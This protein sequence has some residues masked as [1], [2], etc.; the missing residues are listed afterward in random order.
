M[1][2]PEVGLGPPVRAQLDAVY[3]RDLERDFTLF[4]ASVLGTLIWRP[5][6]EVQVR[7]G[8]HDGGRLAPEE[9]HPAD[10]RGPGVVDS[11]DERTRHALDIWV[12]IRFR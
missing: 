1:S 4:K 6:R 2:W 12:P 8:Q 11:V 5:V 3:V 9:D 10:C 7:I